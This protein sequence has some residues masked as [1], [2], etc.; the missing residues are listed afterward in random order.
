MERPSVPSG[1]ASGWASKGQLCPVTAY[2]SRQSRT[3]R[4]HYPVPTLMELPMSSVFRAT[5]N[6]RST[7]ATAL[8]PPAHTP[9]HTSSPRGPR[10][11]LRSSSATPRPG[12]AA[13]WRAPRPR[14]RCTAR[15][16][17]ARHG[18][19]RSPGRAFGTA[20]PILSVL[21]APGA[22]QS[23]FHWPAMVNRKARHPSS[24]FIRNGEDGLA[25]Y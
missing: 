11:A 9:S 15:R 13:P 14:A 16:T 23:R 25:H 5:E 2:W 3:I 22:T 12:G 19:V 17:P 6:V 8:P 1:M 18:R 7:S 20:D 24:H 10:R 4:L 21:S